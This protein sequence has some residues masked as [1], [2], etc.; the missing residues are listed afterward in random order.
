M[1]DL[2]KLYEI[3]VESTGVCTDTRKILKGNLF[4]ALSGPNFNGN[5]FAQKAFDEG[6]IACV[7]NEEISGIPDERLFVV[8]DTLE[9]LQAL[10]THHRQQL[11]IPVF[12]ITGSNG[13][14]TTKELMHHAL[15]VKYKTFATKGNLNNHIGVPLSLLAI[16][17]S[18][19]FAI[20]EMGTNHVGE[21]ASYCK[22]A[23]PNFGL[24]TN[25]GKAHI[26]EFGGFENIIIGKSELFDYLN[27]DNGLPFINTN[28]AVLNN[29][30]KRFANPFTYPNEGDYFEAKLL[31]SQ[32]A[33]QMEVE[34]GIHI[35]TQLFGQFNA[36]NVSAA[37]CVAKYFEVDLKKAAVA[38]EAYTPTNMRSQLIKTD[39]Y[40]I[41]LDAYNANPDSMQLAIESLSASAK[42]E[43]VAILGDM[44]ELGDM[45]TLEH[46]KL[47][48]L[49]V[50]LGISRRIYF[51][52]QIQKAKQADP[53]GT[54]FTNKEVLINHLKEKPIKSGSTI[55]I[56]GSRR[57]G[58]EDLV[59]VLTGKA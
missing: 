34:G 1:K 50:D 58:L 55:L 43:S 26:G 10:A 40:Q 31:P 4:F 19:E 12:G 9:V 5:T 28:D 11:K 54:F 36:N 23:Q 7:V 41:I 15:S 20:I 21:I 24:I 38:I 30:K 25:I 8:D 39:K 27:K 46:E 51:G 22:M 3:Y 13:K 52:E 37:M 45:S 49:A 14:T 32:E 44:L 48:E 2:A 57:N 6:A 47:A 59:E 17:D 42:S 35:K 53:F 29:M 56:K 18:F 33:L 16:D